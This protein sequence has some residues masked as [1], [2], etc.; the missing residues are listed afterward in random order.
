M[1]AINYQ[2]E[3]VYERTTFFISVVVEGDDNVVAY[4]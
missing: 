1:S 2:P 3:N 4:H